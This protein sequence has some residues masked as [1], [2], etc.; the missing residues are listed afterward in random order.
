MESQEFNL[1]Y[2]ADF[3][4]NTVGTS[5]GG[6]GGGGGGWNGLFCLV[7]P[8]RLS[9]VTGLDQE[10]ATAART[11]WNTFLIFILEFDKG[12]KSRDFAG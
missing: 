6:V 7:Y 11:I 8:G 12:A 5:G 9:S 4:M 10:P 3:F 2:F 1:E